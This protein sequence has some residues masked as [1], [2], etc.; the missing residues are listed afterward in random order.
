MNTELQTK[1]KRLYL[2][3]DLSKTE[4]ANALGLPRRTLHYWIKEH[5]WEYQKQSAAHMP[6][7][8]AE[9]CYHILAN[10]TDQLLAPER[11]DEMISLREVNTIHRLS[12]AICKLKNSATLNEKMEIL[13]NFSDALNNKSPEMAKAIAPFVSD[14]LA[15]GAAASLSVPRLQPFPLTPEELEIEN[16]LDQQYLTNEDHDSPIATTPHIPVSV[17]DKIIEAAKRRYNRPSYSE[18][19][20]D[21]RS[22]DD[23]IRHMFPVITRYTPI[24]A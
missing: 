6:V 1:A 10:Y 9:N 4:I 3:T 8:I 12:T 22:Q 24:A 14:Y 19:L 13:S 5:N 20:A 18:M 2:H 7:L 15:A 23:N 17:S 16:Q 21:F 11:K